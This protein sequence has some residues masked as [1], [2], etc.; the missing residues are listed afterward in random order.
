MDKEDSVKER[1]IVFYKNGDDHDC[2][3]ERIRSLMLLFE[4]YEDEY[5]LE[6][7]GEHLE[8]AEFYYLKQYPDEE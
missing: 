3:L 2:V 6:K 5:Y 8:L 7:V 4:D 1:V